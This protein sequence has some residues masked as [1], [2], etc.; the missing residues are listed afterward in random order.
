MP[1]IGNTIRAADDYR[2][3]DDISSSFNGST[4]SFALQVAGSSPVTFP[5]SHQQVLISVNGVIQEPDPTGASGFNL[6]GTN[7][8]FSSAPTNGHAFFG[9]IYATADYLNAGGTNPA[10]SVGAPSITFIGD[11]DTGIYRKGSGSVGFVSNSTEIANTDSNGITISSGGLILGDSSGASSN[12]IKLGASS[13]LQLFHDSTNS[14]I[15]NSTGTLFIAGDIVSL[16]NAAI[17]ETYIKGTANGAVEIYFDNSK[18][19]ETTSSGAHVLGTFEGDNFKVSNPGSNAVLIQNPANGIIGFGANNQTNQ[20]IITTDGHL[21]IPVDSKELRFGA[22]DDLT[23]TH[24]GTNSV[25]DNATGELRIQGDLVRIMNGA[26]NKV[27]IETNVDDNVELYFNNAK[28][29]ETV[30]GGFTVTGTC[31]A[32]AFAGDGSA[33]T[34]ITSTTINNNANNRLITGSGTANTLEGESALTFDG[35]TLDIN[36]GSTD[37]PL[38]LDTT[39]TAGSHLRFRKDGSNK[40]FVGSGGGFGL[41]DVDDLAL[42]TVDNMIFGVSTTEVARFLSSGKFHVLTSSGGDSS[43]GIRSKSAAALDGSSIDYSHSCYEAQ[44]THNAGSNA[45]KGSLLSGWDGNI[46]ATAIGQNYDG[47]GYN[48]SLATNEDTND[49]PIERLRIERTGN[50]KVLDGD[51]VIGASG[52]GVDFSDTGGPDAGS[53]SSTSEILDDYERGTFAAEIVQGL[54]TLNITFDNS[55][56]YEKIGNLVHIQAL[57]Q[58]QGTGNGTQVFLRLPYTNMTD[59]SLGGGLISFT[60]VAG[61]DSQSTLSLVGQSAQSYCAVRNKASNPS[62]SG[63]QN[64]QAIYYHFTYHTS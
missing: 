34:G 1:Y 20:V 53:G 14:V 30:T 27:A 51:L 3:I 12:R 31:T 49:R 36:G 23:I 9:I 24:N 64:N 55:A 42:R 44:L 18:K 37:T 46:Q 52:H 29:A 48:L 22:S 8:V 26:G 59:T 19:F 50:V 28:K 35:S 62:I 7:I 15:S 63:Y 4:T 54:G 39:A 10:G 17:S 38:I 57:I 16:T 43:A 45:K 25:I 5:K 11:E 6:V 47:T 33:L 21:G 40:H 61:L 13:D 2:L 60:N 32:T 41:G 56:T 58:F